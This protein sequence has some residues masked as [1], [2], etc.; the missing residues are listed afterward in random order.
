MESME[1]SMFA[2]TGKIF[3]AV[4]LLVFV[5]ACANKDV[6]S[7]AYSEGDYEKSAQ[8][9]QKWADAGYGKAN[10]KVAALAQ[11]SQKRD[12]S[13]IIKYA[14]KAYDAGEKKAAF[15]LEDSYRKEHNYKEA[16]KW[17]QRGDINSSNAKDVGNHLF[18]I[19]T[20]MKSFTK[21]RAY[22][23]AIAS[24]AEDSNT[25]SIA[26]KLGEF[27]KD[28]SSEFYDI[29]KSLKFYNLAYSRGND[30]AGIKIALI[31][32]YK[33]KEEEKGLEI[34][35]EIAQRGN[36]E[37]LVLIGKYFYGDLQDVL[38]KYNRPCITCNF[39]TPLDFFVK[40]LSLQEVKRR[41]MRENVIPWFERAYHKGDINARIELIA[42]DIKDGNFNTAKEHYS[43]MNLQQAIAFLNGISTHSFK[44]KMVLAQIY[45]NYPALKKVD[46][47]EAT[48]MEYMDQNA[49][50]AKWHLYQLYKKFHQD[51]PKM[52]AY[53]DNLVSVGF[54]PAKVEKSYYNIL[55]SRETN[56]SY[57]LLDYEAKQKNTK[58][59]AYLSSL[60]SKGMIRGKSKEES[61]KINKEICELEPFNVKN[62]LK[63]ANCYLKVQKEHN[64]TKAATIY[65]FYAEQNNTN[66]QYALAGIYKNFCDMKKSAYWYKKAEKL[67]N[68][69]A[70]FAYDIMVLRGE[71]EGDVKEAF[72]LIKRYADNG[73][74]KAIFLLADLYAAGKV[75]DFDPKKALAY[76]NKILDGNELQ[77]Y[78]KIVALYKELNID[79]LYD[80]KIE[81]IYKKM[82]AMGDDASKVPLANFYMLNK[83]YE[84]ARKMLLSLPLEHYPQARYMLYNIT[85]KIKYLHNATES[86]NGNLLLLYANE[87]SRHSRKK[88]L[89]YAFRAS[90][91]DTPR[92]GVLIYNMMRLI[93]DSA[94]IRNIFNE[95]KTYEKCSNMK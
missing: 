27:Y 51:S 74:K 62:D 16:L 5:T 33:L 3:T 56:S 81:T 25:T 11:K 79:H 38:E 84:K 85:G 89:L 52:M 73:N 22:L 26:Y 28:D 35:K 32:I 13:Y 55:Q 31:D 49:T 95:A 6:A 71:V 59:M 21:Q 2:I 86:N 40:K 42:L 29:E 82:I 70:L 15:I 69:N 30:I 36:S 76:Y 41:Y 54:I 75:V 64:V 39:S 8:I 94:T 57:A 45:M 7:R 78:A 66:A 44:A 63:I 19:K 90:L 9:W 67:G 58:A 91:C 72:E 23:D 83:K 47:A 1:H 68:E 14:K 60:I 37:V 34:L 24:L 46:I 50:D 77:V 92:S 10:L 4:L 61:C 20:T 65:K 17:M 12:S 43:H 93:N 80:D 53:L 87:I 48:Y 18:L 88:A